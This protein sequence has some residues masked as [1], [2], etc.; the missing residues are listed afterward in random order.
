MTVLSLLA[1][2]SACATV[3]Q[4]VPDHNQIDACQAV[5][6]SSNADRLAGPCEYADDLAVCLGLPLRERE[7][8]AA[9]CHAELESS[10]E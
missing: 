9:R 5:E 6:R 3:R 1:A 4:A 10:R 7:R 8:I 2:C